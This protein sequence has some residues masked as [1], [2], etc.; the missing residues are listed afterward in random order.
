[1]AGERWERVRLA[2][3]RLTSVHASMPQAK[4]TPLCVAAESNQATVASAL[5]QANANIE[6]KAN[7]Q[8]KGT[9]EA[10]VSLPCEARQEAPPPQ[11]TSSRYNSS[12]AFCMGEVCLSCPC[13]SCLGAVVGVGKGVG[14]ARTGLREGCGGQRIGGVCCGLDDP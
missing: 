13:V 14:G 11:S 10:A 4:R 12:I 1:M 5:I 3:W 6:A 9:I 8:A 7:I 2:R